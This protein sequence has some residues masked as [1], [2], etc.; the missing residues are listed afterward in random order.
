MARY[1]DSSCASIFW[2]ARMDASSSFA[3]GMQGDGDGAIG[4][5][6]GAGEDKGVAG[7]DNWTRGVAALGV[8]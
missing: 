3:E 5:H 6:P 8:P 7:S 4:T 2:V 1:W